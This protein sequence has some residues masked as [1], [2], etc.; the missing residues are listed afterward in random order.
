MDHG[1]RSGR[2]AANL[3]PVPPATGGPG[4]GHRSR[5]KGQPHRE[6]GHPHG[7]GAPHGCVGLVTPGST[8][9]IRPYASRRVAS[10]PD[11]L[12]GSGGAS[13]WDRP[14]RPG[15]GDSPRNRVRASPRGQSSRTGERGERGWSARRA[16]LPVGG[17]PIRCA[18]FG[19][20]AIVS[21]HGGR[22]MSCDH[23][24]LGDVQ[25]GA[26]YSPHTKPRKAHTHCQVRMTS[27]ASWAI[28]TY[29]FRDST[30]YGTSCPP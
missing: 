22:R 9:A 26:T 17:I 8:G 16:H 4:P 12:C 24:V 27:V 6:V 14:P 20:A 30:T 2:G 19:P 21:H 10:Q 25:R 18:D 28:P 29:R 3:T 7:W 11:G 5:A 1:L 13:R 23:V 15:S